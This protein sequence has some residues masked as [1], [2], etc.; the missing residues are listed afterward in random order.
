MG[1]W[2]YAIGTGTGECWR[3]SDTYCRIMRMNGV[4]TRLVSGNFVGDGSGH[5]LR[6]LIYLPEAGWVPIEATSAV[7]S[8]RQ[9]AI[10]FFGTWGG[11]LLVG[12][13]NIDFTLPGPKGPWN[14][15]TLDGLAFGGSGGK[16]DFPTPKFIAKPL[17]PVQPG[18]A[19]N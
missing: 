16:W 10:Q 18:A 3:I 14:I 6:S 5:H 17:P 2:H 13:R 8:P 12:N 9:P 1:L 4:P 11:S 7:S 19:A 15:G